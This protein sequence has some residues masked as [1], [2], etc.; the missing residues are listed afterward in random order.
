MDLKRSCREV[1]RIVLEGQ[2][3]A[4][5]T[6]ERMALQMHWGICVTCRKFRDQADLMRQA[7][8]R[9]RGYRDDDRPD[10]H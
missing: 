7:M 9:W 4:L 2:D 5:S 8:A 6:T 10:G 1:T 3:R